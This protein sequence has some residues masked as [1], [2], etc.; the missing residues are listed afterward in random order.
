MELAQETY[1]VLQQLHKAQDVLTQAR[2]I[3]QV[4]LCLSSQDQQFYSIILDQYVE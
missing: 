3:L 2:H 4:F 1:Q